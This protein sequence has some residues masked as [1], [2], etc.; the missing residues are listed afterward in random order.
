MVELLNTVCM[1]WT[2]DSRIANT[3]LVLMKIILCHLMNYF[4]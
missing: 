1:N 3:V 2:L 4:I